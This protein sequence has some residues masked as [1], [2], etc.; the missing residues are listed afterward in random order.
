MNNNK[1]LLKTTIAVT[2]ILL[3][4][5]NNVLAQNQSVIN[6]ISGVDTSEINNAI[7]TAVPFL[8]VS[9]DPRAGGIGDAG[10]ANFNDINALHWNLSKMAFIEKPA[11]FAI[12]YSPWLRALV[13]DMHL[14]YL[15][16]YGR[17]NKRQTIAGAIKY[18][19]LGKI[20][21]TD[22]SG[23][24]IRTANPSEFSVD[25]G[26]AQK[27][28]DNFSIGLTL[29]YVYS[30]LGQ[31]ISLQGGVTT[32]PGQAA[33]ADISSTFV[34]NKFKVSGKE[35]KYSGALIVSNIGNKIRYTDASVNG[36]FQPTNLRI[37]NALKLDLD[38]YNS[39]TFLFDINKLLVPT[40]PLLDANRNIV[41]GTDPNR[42]PINAIFT[43]FSDAPNGAQEEFREFIFNGGVEYWYDNLLA[44]RAGG[45]YEHTTKGNRKYFTMGLGIRYSSFGFDFSYLATF[46][47]NPL[48]NTLRFTLLF[49]FEALKSNNTQITAE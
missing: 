14:T 27:L 1:T 12:S 44:V 48:K 18:F 3:L 40:P 47:Q 38:K 43:S 11:G 17:I 25:L 30:N 2:F 9:P 13:N 35:L 10:G 16:G 26:L 45:F 5:L 29:R 33:G 24:P 19:N 34:S 46:A 28:S 22:I 20:E 7:T 6:Q 31:G 4:Q 49:D 37:G 39:M 41:K 23:N 32:Q 42:S 15:T 36:D 8:I 21:F